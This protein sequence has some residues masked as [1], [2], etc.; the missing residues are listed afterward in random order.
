MLLGLSRGRIQPIVCV[1]K[2]DLLAEGDRDSLKAVVSPYR[3]LEVPV[4]LCSAST[5]EGLDELR[6]HLAATTC[7]FVGH[8]GVGKSS[9]LNAIDPQGDRSTGDVRDRDGKGRHI[10]TSSSLRKLP[11]G[12]RVIDTPGI[13]AFGLDQ[14]TP[15]QV[16]AGFVEFE[17]F[18]ARCRYGD[19]THVQEPDCAVRASVEEGELSEARYQSYA[20]ILASL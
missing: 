5:G 16:R 19:C 20:R 10:T 1:N 9:I 2:V 18:T 3:E 13:R 7:V 12:T 8:S 4:V 6:R 15:E 17:P 14:R 11:D